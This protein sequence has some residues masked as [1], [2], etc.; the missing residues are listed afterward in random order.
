MSTNVVTEAKVGQKFKIDASN[1]NWEDIVAIRKIC[2]EAAKALPDTAKPKAEI[3]LA[4]ESRKALAVDALDVLLGMNKV[5]QLL[6]S[7]RV[8]KGIQVPNKALY[9]LESLGINN[10]QR[11]N[12]L[13]T[14]LPNVL[15]CFSKS[16]VKLTPRQFLERLAKVCDMDEAKFASL[17][18]SRP[19]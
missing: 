18:R 16:L 8:E 14:K 12:Y 13:M 10:V 5:F 1:L 17:Q 4:K 11:F 7:W 2:S 6:K 9:T 15:P 3:D 19:K